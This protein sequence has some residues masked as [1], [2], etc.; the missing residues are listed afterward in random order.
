MNGGGQGQ[1]TGDTAGGLASFNANP[2]YTFQMPSKGNATLTLTNAEPQLTGRSH[3]GFYLFKR[4]GKTQI[5]II[6]ETIGLQRRKKK[7]LPETL[8][9]LKNNLVE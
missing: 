2:Q 3:M 1:W 6:L 4:D 8:E 7:V 5:L 9:L